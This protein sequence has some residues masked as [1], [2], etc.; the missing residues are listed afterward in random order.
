M[1]SGSLRCEGRVIHGGSRVA[2]AEGK[3]FDAAGKLC[4]H[5]TTT[6]MILDVTETP[7]A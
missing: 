2:T 1:G 6:C 5:A 7:P 4:A 3:V